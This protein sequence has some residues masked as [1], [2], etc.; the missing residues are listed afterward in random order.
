MLCPFKHRNQHVQI[1]ELLCT[2][3]N[4]QCKPPCLPGNPLLP[5]AP[6]IHHQRDPVTC[7]SQVKPTHE[8]LIQLKEKEVESAG[9]STQ[10]HAP[11]L[12]PSRP[13][14]PAQLQKCCVVCG[15]FPLQPAFEPYIKALLRDLQSVATI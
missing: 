2:L 9:L 14:L 8:G 5:L 11:R 1:L 7:S 13:S 10:F 3:F 6:F 12:P 15:C 4:V